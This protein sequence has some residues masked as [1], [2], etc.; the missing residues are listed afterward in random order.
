M[1][2]YTSP[3]QKIEDYIIK[4]NISRE[5]AEKIVKSPN[6]LLNLEELKIK[7]GVD[8]IGELPDWI[9]EEQLSNI[10]WAQV[11]SI[12]NKNYEYYK[13]WIEKEDL[14]M[15]LQID[16]RIL[17][18]NLQN[19][20][21][22][23]TI[24]INDIKTITNTH[25]RR[26]KYFQQ[27]LDNTVYTDNDVMTYADIISDNNSSI[28]NS[29]TMLLNKIL[30]IK[31]TTTRHILISIAYLYCNISIFR[32]SYLD[33]LKE[34]DE[35][36]I[37]KLNNLDNLIMERDKMERDLLD[38]KPINKKVKKVRVNNIVSIF[39]EKGQNVP[40]LLDN[41]RNYIVTYDLI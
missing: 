13:T 4:Y 20:R 2:K 5:E 9:T 30:N 17:I 23:K 31:D 37:N 15:Q 29:D 35:D 1:R 24:I 34:L 40:K 27:S 11:H 39:C 22:L 25:I 41:I 38:K 36:K 28:D 12:Y 33:M 21:E 19:F 32:Q 10:I 26:Q 18:Y 14:Y 16:I 3:K 7:S 6:N 8:H